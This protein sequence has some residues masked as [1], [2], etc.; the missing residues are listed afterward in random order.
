MIFKEDI[1]LIYKNVSNPIFEWRKFYY[2]CGEMDIVLNKY[3][4]IIKNIF[5]K[6]ATHYCGKKKTKHMSLED[7]RR[8]GKDAEILE[9]DYD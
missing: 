9:I 6:Y 5:D 7:F 4:V 2:I 1:L 3:M 8:I